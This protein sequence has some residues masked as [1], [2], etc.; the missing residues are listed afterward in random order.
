[1]TG[2]QNERVAGKSFEES[3][4][5]Q[6]LAS[7]RLSPFSIEELNIPGGGKDVD[8]KFDSTSSFDAEKLNRSR[9][10]DLTTATILPDS[11]SSSKAETFKRPIACRATRCVELLEQLASSDRDD[12]KAAS[13]LLQRL[14]VWNLSSHVLIKQDRATL[15]WRL[16]K[17]L[18]VQE[19]FI[20]PLEKLQ[21]YLIHCGALMVK[22]NTSSDLFA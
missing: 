10:E 9:K 16:R 18:G 12:A 17:M 1:M 15:D 5:D 4:I 19:F 8:S 6:P 11:T 13:N 21:N 22:S 14:N 2:R 3:I 7:A 20:L